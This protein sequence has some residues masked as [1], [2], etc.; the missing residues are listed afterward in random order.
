[1]KNETLKNEAIAQLQKYV[2]MDSEIIVV[3]HS[4]NKSGMSR[5]LSAYVVGDNKKLM[6]LNTYLAQ[7]GIFK[8]DNSQKIIVRGFGTDMLFQLSYSIKSALFG[9]ASGIKNQQYYSIC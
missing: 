2:A 4:V 9:T 6:C 5:K 7:A 8:I 3:M 1:M